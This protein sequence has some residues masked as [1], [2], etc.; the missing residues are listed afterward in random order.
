MVE[1]AP[2]EKPE[3]KNDGWDW[4][5]FS[6]TVVGEEQYAKNVEMKDKHHRDRMLRGERDM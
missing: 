4:S 6:A 2:V 5:M 3:D 1:W